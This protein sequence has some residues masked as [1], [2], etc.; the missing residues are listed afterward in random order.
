MFVYDAFVDMTEWPNCCELGK[1]PGPCVT[2]QWVVVGGTI[3]DGWNNGG[4]TMPTG[5]H[6]LEFVGTWDGNAFDVT[7]VVT[8][9]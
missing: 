3:T 2:Y 8:V 7:V 6:T 5:D 4:G 1:T 9:G